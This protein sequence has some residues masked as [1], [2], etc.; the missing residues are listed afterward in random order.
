MLLFV[1]VVGGLKVVDT[2]G[3]H[4]VTFFHSLYAAAKTKQK[5]FERWPKSELRTVGAGARAGEDLAK[6]GTLK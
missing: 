5:R 2:K 6:H 3:L 4:W 1:V